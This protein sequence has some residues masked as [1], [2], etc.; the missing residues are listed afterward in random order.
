M[1]FTSLLAITTLLAAAMV[2][3]RLRR[4]SNDFIKGVENDCSAKT[5]EACPAIGYSNARYRAR[6][7]IWNACMYAQWVAYSDHEGCPHRDADFL[8][9][10]EL[11]RTT[12]Y[13][14]VIVRLP[15]TLSSTRCSRVQAKSPSSRGRRLLC[16][17]KLVQ[18]P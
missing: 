5:N 13:R 1:R 2:A 15:P 16:C 9:Q 11:H 10:G 7:T 6:E 3:A 17:V 4:P 12:L 8:P 14:L 18:R